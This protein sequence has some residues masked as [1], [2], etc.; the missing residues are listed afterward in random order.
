MIS[1]KFSAQEARELTYAA[2][3]A[4]F[5][6]ELQD[7][8]QEIKNEASKGNGSI[9]TWVSIKATTYVIQNLHNLNFVTKLCE[10]DQSRKFYTI[11]WE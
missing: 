10:S 11:S 7:I 2:K 6:K 1:E 3:T 5:E 9:N 4:E 8:L